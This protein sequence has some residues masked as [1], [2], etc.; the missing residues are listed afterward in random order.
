MELRVLRY[1]QAVVREQ[2]ISR[3]AEMLHV[4]QPTVSRQLKDLEDE[5]GLTLFVRG[6]RSIQ[7]TNSGEYFASQV[8]QILSLTDKTLQNLHEE[9][10]IN[11]RVVI[12]SAEARTFL[13]VAQSISTLQ[14]HYPHIQTSIISTNADEIRTSIKSGYF[15][16]G[17]IMEPADKTDYDFIHLPGESRWG[18][19]MPG[20]APLANKDHLQLSDL[21][22]MKLILSSQQGMTGL[23][24]D[25]LGKSTANINVVATYNLLY[26]AALM[27]SAGVGYSLCFDGIINTNQSDLKFVP[28][29]PRLT[30]GASIV[31]RKGQRL[32][33]AAKAFLQ[34]LQRDLD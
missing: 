12:G 28:F 7:L 31:W 27:V 10:Q 29:E 20:D 5:L 30:S 23:L 15:D 13:N 25:W 32:S 24:D 9:Q 6:T 34:Q 8:D 21:A 3:A 17:V 16:F 2:N 14:Q 22:Q 18:V 4:S 33:L 1:F 11:G 19:L 26:N